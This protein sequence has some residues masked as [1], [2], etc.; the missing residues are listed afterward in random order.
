MHT[1]IRLIAVLVFLGG[2]AVNRADGSAQL[3]FS[4]NFNAADTNT[5]D[6]APTAGRLGGTLADTVFLRSAKAQQS[7][8]GNQLRT[9]AAS[10]A[11][12]GR[13]RFQNTD[14][15]FNWAA[16]ET[17]AAIL[18]AGRLRVE[19]DWTT[20]ATDTANWVAFSIGHSGAAA[21]EP[22]TRVN[23]G[24]TDYGVRFRGNGGAQRFDNGSM[25]TIGSFTPSPETRHITLD[26]ALGSF[27]D[28]ASV[29]GFALIDGILLDTHAFT[30][31]GN[32]GSIHMELESLETGM[33]IDN[34]SVSAVSDLATACTLGYASCAEGP[35]AGTDTVVL[36]V[37]P[38]SASWLASSDAPWLRLPAAAGTGGTNLLFTFD[39]NAG[40]TRT[41]VVTVAGQTLRVVQAGAAYVAANP[42]T[43]LFSSLG[44][45]AS[46]AADAAG[47]VYVCDSDSAVIRKWSVAD[48]TFSTL[49][50]SGLKNPCGV[51]TDA[52]GNLYIADIGD[53]TI[54]KWD[55]A[56]QL[57]TWVASGL[58][59]PQAV[60]VDPAGNLYIADIG[61]YAIKKWDAATGNITTLVN[62]MF[63][64]SLT[65][66]GSNAVIF[67][68]AS[69]ADFTCRVGA[70]MIASG[71]FIENIWPD[72]P[73]FFA[74]R[75]LYVSVSPQSG[76]LYAAYKDSSTIYWQEGDAGHRWSRNGNWTT[77]DASASSP[78]ALAATGTGT[79]YFADAADN[80]LRKWT[81]T[82]YG[83]WGPTGMTCVVASPPL[84]SPGGIAVDA[85]GN[86]FFSSSGNGLV[87]KWA[88]DG[89]VITLVS[90]GLSAPAG[91]A[92]DPAG[93][94][95][96]ADAGDGSVKR[97]NAA[98]GSMTTQLIAGLSS[99]WDV[100]VDAAT[101]LYIADV[102][103]RAIGMCPAGSTALVTLI[104]TS[105][106]VSYGV[107]VD[108]AGNVY[109]LQASWPQPTLL[110]WR[111]ADG[112]QHALGSD[113]FEDPHGI[114]VDGGG[115][116]CIADTGHDAVMRWEAADGQ[117]T[118]VITEDGIGPR[119][120]YGV[121]VDADR[122][123][124]VADTGHNAIK[125]KP[126]AFV[127]ASPVSLAGA[128]GAGAL[129]PVLPA[130]VNLA[131]PF[132]PTSDQDWLTITGATNGVVSY[133]YTEAPPGSVAHITLL[134][135]SITVT[136][137]RSEIAVLGINGEAVADSEAPSAAKGTDFGFV[138]RGLA[139]TNT[140]TMTNAG[141]VALSIPGWAA[142]G[143]NSGD[144][145]LLNVPS[146]VVAGGC[147]G[148]QIVFS[149]TA[150][151]ASTNRVTFSNDSTNSLFRL[152]L[153]GSAPYLVTPA[154]GTNGTLTPAAPVSV[155]AGGST[156]FVARANTY[157][158]IGQ[159]LSNGVADA[160]AAGAAVYTS[161]WEN[162]RADGTLQAAFAANV[163]SLGTP[164]WWLAK[165]G[166]T[167]GFNSWETKD[168]DGDGLF[169]WQE[170][171]A[172]T[173]PTNA[174]SRF[175]ITS[176][177]NS[178]P[179]CV[180]FNASTGRLYTLF[181]ATNLASGVWSAVPG[182]GPRLGAGGTDTLRDT[183][184]PPSG[185]FYKLKVELP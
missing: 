177:S 16:D 63:P 134:G 30:W 38:P 113:M 51:A 144:F 182:A 80:T 95:Y 150:G 25:T 61:D 74:L 48:Q 141:P 36:A 147:A 112:N 39:A 119:H 128:S 171:V 94:L 17:G 96:I 151:G 84:S 76:Y 2:F 168:T 3:L 93:N 12:S 21:G 179:P 26:F 55:A 29:T 175:A 66:D 31:D 160:G 184:R 183:N 104:S 6:A 111:A 62:V 156:G 100:A 178:P 105:P 68:Y 167:G 58:N 45:P 118:G 8:Q 33:R 108:A 65:V 60:G 34:Y 163:A 35:E 57:T 132:T 7:I 44:T 170:Y 139:V 13:V 14:G 47:N 173:D 137:V 127:D 11:V 81:Q 169:A 4:D 121:A 181:A 72:I 107:D 165:Y 138:A 10:G 88:P 22:N 77:I 120:P 91:V 116:V 9:A 172:D 133:G 157:Y 123:V 135:Q 162:V 90:A 49:I 146:S 129:P 64:A 136:R 130:T 115:S 155:N 106:D 1:V 56:G 159:L 103:V 166:W 67:S 153:A 20:T 50:G 145:T 185:S 98:A 69:D 164:E 158:R 86:V 27:A 110:Q 109:G 92:L 143:P 114:A 125:E 70:W 71:E 87:G 54:K 99:P 52:A 24:Q 53:Y 43:T 23:H 15:W 122:N 18:G 152:N 126:R 46:A 161:R 101:N 89:T 148:L 124:Y 102:G 97:W 149:S 85:R 42:L 142:V 180:F 117:F 131:G 174:A 32:G 73:A 37:S 82:G 140:L 41:G 40:A 19:F 79:L 5:F 75:P 59:L 78:A 176:M 83:A 28:G 154:C